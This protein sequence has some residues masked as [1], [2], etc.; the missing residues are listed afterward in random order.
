[1]FD[2]QDNYASSLSAERAEIEPHVMWQI[3]V[4]SWAVAAFTSTSPFETWPQWGSDSRSFPSSDPPYILRCAIYNLV[5]AWLVHL[6]E[7]IRSKPTQ[8]EAVHGQT[9]WSF[10]FPNAANKD[11]SVKPNIVPWKAGG[12][13]Y[14]LSVYA[15]FIGPYILNLTW[16]KNHILVL[17]MF[18]TR[19]H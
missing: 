9:E 18:C 2:R 13:N 4:S 10:M 15:F 14:S 1:M 19:S 8:S 17:I 7:I 16:Q 3:I 6:Y 11:Y 12:T 5:E